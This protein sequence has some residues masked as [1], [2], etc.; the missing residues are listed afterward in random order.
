MKYIHLITI[1]LLGCGPAQASADTAEESY[2]PNGAAL[3]VLSDF[4]AQNCPLPP[5]SG[6]DRSM[7]GSA[8]IKFDLPK[9]LSKLVDVGANV[10][11][12]A[13]TSAYSGVTQE[14][15]ADVIKHSSD[16]RAQLI[17]LVFDR[18]L[19]SGAS[20]QTDSANIVEATMS[21]RGEAE[22]GFNPNQYFVHGIVHVS[23]YGHGP[24]Q[25]NF[26]TVCFTE[27]D[28]SEESN[29]CYDNNRYAMKAGSDSYR[30]SIYAPGG[31][32][33][34]QGK[35]EVSVMVCILDT[36]TNLYFVRPRSER[37]SLPRPICDIRQV[38]F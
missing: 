5:M 15:L 8:E 28:A 11:G 30:F 21:R 20:A 4:A 29:T 25:S 9:L 3:Q 34:R 38:K 19:G 27:G 35:S 14:Q 36:A 16:C 17:T 6:S 24:Y 31:D 7:S 1:F 26:F 10:K 37:F 12:D 22:K 23:Y 13:R 18:V 32:E 33:W 2:A